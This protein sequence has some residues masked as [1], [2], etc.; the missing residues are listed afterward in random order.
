MTAALLVVRAKDANS[1]QKI[2]LHLGM[3]SCQIQKTDGCVTPHPQWAGV[4]Q[5]QQHK[6]FRSWSSWL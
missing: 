6:E 4:K 5:M 2:T 1:I 3:H